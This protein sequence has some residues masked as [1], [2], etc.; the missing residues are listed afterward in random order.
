MTRRYVKRRACQNFWRCKPCQELHECARPEHHHGPCCN[1]QDVVIWS[2]PSAYG[3]T[4]DGQVSLRFPR[5]DVGRH[6]N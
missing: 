1:K 2:T 5:P 4:W 6:M 3:C